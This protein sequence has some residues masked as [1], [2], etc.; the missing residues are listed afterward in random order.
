MDQFMCIIIRIAVQPVRFYSSTS[1]CVIFRI[2]LAPRTAN[3]FTNVH[4]SR[5]CC[6]LP[7]DP[8]HQIDYKLTPTP[9]FAHIM[10][11]ILCFALLVFS[12]TTTTIPHVH[13]ATPA[14]DYAQKTGPCSVTQAET[15]LPQSSTTVLFTYPQACLRSRAPSPVIVFW[16]GL[17]AKSSYYN[18]LTKKL[19]SWG[20]AVVQYD[21]PASFAL[22]SSSISTELALL[23]AFFTWLQAQSASNAS[24]PV[25]NKLNMNIIFF[26]GHSRG[27]KVAGL[28]WA[29]TA[30][31]RV[32]G[33][34]LIDPV[35]TSQ[36]NPISPTN[37]SAVQA[38]KKSGKRIGVTGASLKGP[39]N[40]AQGDYTKFFAAGAVGSWEEVINGASHTSFLDAGPILNAVQDKLCGGGGK[41][42]R[43]TVVSLTAT[44]I[45]QYFW[46][47]RVGGSGGGSGSF[48]KWVLIQEKRG[49]M[50]LRVKNMMIGRK[51]M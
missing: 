44:P 20:Y 34:W 5:P 7:R 48:R 46:N 11:L 24:S 1:I 29:E 40:P 49:V 42:D 47:Q 37:P 14:P 39:C 33:A 27:G 23:P 50:Q 15:A 30:D 51:Q 2:F 32:K 45:L 18:T 38:L 8:L 6:C 21:V 16:N 4:R 3:S 41:L 26:S 43:Q 12:T 13:A 19:A 10:R 36:Y 35:D 9:I 25:Y 17:M 28:S 22:N 31:A